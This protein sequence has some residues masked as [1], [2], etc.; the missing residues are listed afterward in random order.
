ML[1]PEKVEAISCEVIKTLYKRFESF[2]EDSSGIR[3]APFHQAFLRAFQDKLEEHV[4]NIPVF[5]SLSSWFHGL[6]TTLG[7]SFFENTAHILSEGE[8]REF[9]ALKISQSQ[10][11]AITDIVTELKNGTYAPSLKRENQLLAAHEHPLEKSISNFTVDCF[12]EDAKRIVAIEIKTVKPNSSIFKS[13]K[14]KILSAKAG[15]KNNSPTKDVLYYLGFPFDPLSTIPTGSDKKR[16]MR[17]SVDFTRFFDSDEVLL[18]NELWDMLSGDS[19]TMQQLLDII[20]AIATPQ[21]VEQFNFLNDLKHRVEN[22]TKYVALLKQW[23]LFSELKLINADAEL[24]KKITGNSVLLRKF[25]Q[26]LFKDGEY[27]WKRFS[28]LHSILHD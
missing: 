17:Y 12:F 9:K 19:N 10:Q 22:R 27:N 5:I 26:S 13:E 2:P 16:F 7:Q 14:D 15:L 6:N 20:N 11:T 8:K 24:Q 4:T 1:P 28:S 21:F 23:H 18:G 25:H 3:N